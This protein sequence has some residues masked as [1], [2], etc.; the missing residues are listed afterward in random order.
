[1]LPV[2]LG[3]SQVPQMVT[4]T[5]RYPAEL[6]EKVRAYTA[7]HGTTFSHFS[8]TTLE[9]QLRTLEKLEQRDG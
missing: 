5:A 9:M 1:M 6:A 3:M 7:A 2:N 8:R 4:L